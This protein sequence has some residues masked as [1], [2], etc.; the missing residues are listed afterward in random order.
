MRLGARMGQVML[1]GIQRVSGFINRSQTAIFSSGKEKDMQ[2]QDSRLRTYYP[3]TTEEPQ[4]TEEL[5][6]SG[7]EQPLCGEVGR[8]PF[9][10]RFCSRFREPTNIGKTPTFSIDTQ[11]R[12]LIH[13]TQIR[14]CCSSCRL[15]KS[16][17]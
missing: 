4:K 7:K 14:E 16:N 3:M 12:A 1:Q 15:T 8:G 2:E 11:F 9:Y 10:R 6:C 13:Y 5:Q 17:G